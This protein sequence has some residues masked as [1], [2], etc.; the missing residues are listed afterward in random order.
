MQ[1]MQSLVVAKPYE[2]VRQYVHGHFFPRLR[3]RRVGAWIEIIGPRVAKETENEFSMRHVLEKNVALQITIYDATPHPSVAVSVTWHWSGF[4]MKGVVGTIATCGF[5]LLVF[6]PV[7][8][9]KRGRCRA[10]FEKAVQLLKEDLGA[11][12]GQLPLQV[13]TA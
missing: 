5:G 11:N 7:F 9:V 10:N 1:L 2:E 8:L 12:E 13:A 4:I 3:E 6:V